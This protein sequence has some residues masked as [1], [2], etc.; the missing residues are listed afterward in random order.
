MLL[1]FINENPKMLVLGFCVSFISFFCYDIHKGK[2]EYQEVQIVDKIYVPERTNTSYRV[3]VTPNGET[4]TRTVTNVEK[5]KFLFM[6]KNKQG[7][8]KKLKVAPEIY[9]KKNVKDEILIEMGK[10]GITNIVYY[11]TPILNVQKGNW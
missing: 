4:N 11:I 3:S 2:K 8:I 10:G 7:K 1:D 9:Y 6:L 5:E